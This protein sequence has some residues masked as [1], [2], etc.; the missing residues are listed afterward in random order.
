MCL[1]FAKPC[2][3]RSMAKPT[4]DVRG[5][6]WVSASI[7]IHGKKAGTKSSKRQRPFCLRPF[8]LR[9]SMA[10]SSRHSTFSLGLRRNG[11]C[12]HAN[13]KWHLC[14]APPRASPGR[15]SEETHGEAGHLDSRRERSG[16]LVPT[17]RL[18]KCIVAHRSFRVAPARKRQP[19]Q[20][21]WFRELG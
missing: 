14:G 20:T 2:E 8:E 6:V 9:L 1:T 11:S 19:N 5:V 15:L 4:S 21:R 16:A 17:G 10:A 18:K 3:K 13:N 7:D 12:T